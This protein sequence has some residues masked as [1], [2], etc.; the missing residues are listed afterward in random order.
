MLKRA[1]SSP[2]ITFGAPVPALMFDTWNV[3]GWKYWL[4]WSQIARGQLGQR[5]RDGMHRV[6]CEMRIGN[7]A[8]HAVDGQLARERAAAADLDRIPEHVGAGRLADH[9]PVESSR[10]GLRALP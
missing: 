10:R 3:V 4:P 6:V 5:R 2:G 1:F 9:A 8:L 7:V